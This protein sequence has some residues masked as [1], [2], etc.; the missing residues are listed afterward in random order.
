[1]LI[2]SI[3][4][5]ITTP[6]LLSFWLSESMLDD[7]VIFTRLTL[8]GTMVSAFETPISRAMH[9]TGKIKTYQI[10]NCIVSFVALPIVF[11]LFKMGF[12][13][14]WAYVISISILAV[15]ILYRL[16]ILH[17]HVSFSYKEYLGVVLLPILMVTA[18]SIFFSMFLVSFSIG[19]VILKLFVQAICSASVIFALIYLIGL[20][21]NEKAY[22]VK[23]LKSKIGK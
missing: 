14:Y 12:S 10:L 7:M 8:I 21:K 11:V 2:L 23:I 16:M 13:A 15:S 18:V 20:N 19:N 22:I 5:I 1:M 9:A 4:L 3:P 6:E 17:Q